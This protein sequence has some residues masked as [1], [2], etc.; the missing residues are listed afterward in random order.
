MYNIIIIF[1]LVPNIIFSQELYSVDSLSLETNV[2]CMLLDDKKE[3]KKFNRAESVIIKG[4]QDVKR[5]YDAMDLVNKLTSPLHRSVLKTEIYWLREK[6][7]EAMNQGLRVIENC[8]DE[9]PYVYYFLGHISFIQKDYVASANYLKKSIELELSDPYYSDAIM[10]YEK[11]KIL[12]DIINNPVEFKPFVIKGISSKYDEYLAIISPDQEFA[13]YTR[14]LIK[15]TKQDIA[16]TSVEEFTFSQKKDGVFSYGDA[17]RYP[18]NLT[19]NEGG[20][21]VT[22]DNNVLYYTKCSRDS[23]GY[24]NCDIYYTTKIKSLDGTYRWSESKEFPK[25]ISKKNAWDSQP[26]VSSDGNTIIFSSNRKGGYGKTDLY[27]ITFENN[28]WSVPKNLGTNINSAEEEKSPFLH[29]DGKTLFFSSTNF[30]TLGGFDIFYSR[31]DSLGKWQKPINIGYPIN[32]STDEVSLFVSTDGKTA[33]FASNKLIGE[34]GWDIYGFPLYEDAKPERVLF[35]KGDLNDEDGTFVKDIEIEIKNL[36]TQKITT[37]K[38]DKGSYVGAITLEDNDDVL[39]SIK[40]EGYAF[41]S[42]YIDADDSNYISPSTLNIELEQ[43]SEGSSF[44]IDNIY[45][46]TNS[47]EINQISEQVI[48]EFINY[49]RVN[50]SIVIEI[51]GYT[52]NV[53]SFRDNQVLSE[54]R[55]KAVYEHIVSNGIQKNRISYNGF[56]EEFP[57][58]S[59]DNEEGRSKNRRTEFKVISK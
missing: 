57:V 18:F 17:M 27:E 44:K 39:L 1:L 42:E 30:P 16:E 14:R 48:N 51:N 12:S 34:G 43:I 56:G 38:V 55:A 23:K 35:L 28:Q 54:N 40:E 37:I 11:A 22:I 9:F 25:S 46:N 19:D 15:K 8:P 36:T 3:R 6:Y 32:T 33:Y 26:T 7:F 29:T 59:N 24:N 5:L 21:T 31:K 53:G 4:R 50:K 20:A 13:F 2:D 58:D 45:F 52:D 41:Y 10:M 47:Y 49:L